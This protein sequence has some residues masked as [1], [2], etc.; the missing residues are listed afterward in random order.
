MDRNDRRAH[1]A[2][3]SIAVVALAAL[4]W[5]ILAPLDWLMRR[6]K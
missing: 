5:A 6:R 3:L 1:G 4:S 2:E